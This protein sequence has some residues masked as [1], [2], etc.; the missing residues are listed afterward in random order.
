MLVDSHKCASTSRIKSSMASQGWVA[1]RALPLIRANPTIGVSELEKALEQKYNVTIGY[2][3]VWAGRQLALEGMWSIFSVG[4]AHV[5]NGKYLGN[6]ASMPCDSSVA[7]GKLIWR[8]MLM[9]SSPWLNLK[10]HMLG[11]CNR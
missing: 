3:K 11:L 8:T 5:E 4:N 2:G 10:L 9:I 7:I 6:H 1:D